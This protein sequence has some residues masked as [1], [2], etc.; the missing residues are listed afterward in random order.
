MTEQTEN[1]KLTEMLNE[2][3]V[4]GLDLTRVLE[5]ITDEYRKNMGYKKI[6]ED[7]EST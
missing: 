4:E 2:S 3:A 6:G 1:E 7:H 5:N